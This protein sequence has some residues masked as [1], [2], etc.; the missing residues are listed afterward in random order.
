MI[1]VEEMLKRIEG[2][3]DLK[4]LNDL[5]VELLGKKSEIN[6]AMSKMGQLDPSE[7]KE[8]GAKIN[9]IRNQVQNAIDTKSKDLE[10]QEVLKKLESEKIDITLKGYDYSSGSKSTLNKVIDE[11]EDIFVGM[12]YEVKEGPEVETDRFNFELMNVPAGHPARDMQDTFYISES[13]LLRTHTSPVQAHAM[14]KAA[15]KPIRIICPGK[16]YRRDDDDATHSH[17][18]MQCEGLVIGEN[19]TVADLKGGRN[20][21]IQPLVSSWEGWNSSSK[22]VLGFLLVDQTKMDGSDNWTSDGGAETYIKKLGK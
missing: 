6:L 1:E 14:E 12:G 16:T 11:I 3:T 15:G 19:I 9:G 4:A 7:R 13:T 5:R 20:G 17:Q 2:A 22:N 21:E 8:Y 10:E 18:F